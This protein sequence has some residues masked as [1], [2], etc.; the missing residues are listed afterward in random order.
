MVMA[1][2]IAC[3]GW[4]RSDKVDDRNRRHVDHAQQDVVGEHPCGDQRAVALQ[5]P[6]DVL[7]GLPL[8]HPDLVASRNRVTSELDHGKLGGMTG[9]RRCLLEDEGCASASERSPER[10]DW[11]PAEL[12]HS[13]DL[14]RRQVGDLEQMPSH[15]S[16]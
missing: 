1:S 10:L 4:A 13:S 2:A 5:D 6:H 8:V 15:A 9:P 11:L 7:D 16:T 12:Q 3:N 14:F